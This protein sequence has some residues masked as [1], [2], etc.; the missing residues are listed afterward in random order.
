MLISCAVAVTDVHSQHI[1][2]VFSAVPVWLAVAHS[3]VRHDV[4]GFRPPH[5]LFF[6]VRA[7]NVHER[8]YI[9]ESRYEFL[10]GHCFLGV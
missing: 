6:S 7:V 1:K 10:D 3:R 8:V 4:T 5:T 2:A 9:A